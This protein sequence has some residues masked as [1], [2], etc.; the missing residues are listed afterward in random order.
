M[1]APAESCVN[2]APCR[3][4]HELVAEYTALFKYARRL[5]AN[6][7]EAADLVQTVMLRALSQASDTPAPENLGA[8]LRTVLFRVFVDERR[9][10][11]RE[12]LSD[13]SALDAYGVQEEPP[14]PSWTFVTVDEVR[15]SVSRLPVH[16]RE[17][18]ELFTFNQ[19][20]YDKI[21]A[22]LGVPQNTVGTRINRARRMLRTLLHPG[23]ISERAP[24]QAARSGI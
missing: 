10:A 5:T 24:Q 23:R 12:T 21:A 19:F 3:G 22:T 11:T 1:S 15:T 4:P 2:A 9:R 17:P 16:F 8:W 18:Y 7:A 14:P 6:P 13:G 20:S